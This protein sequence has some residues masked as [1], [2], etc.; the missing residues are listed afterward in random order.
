MKDIALPEYYGS[1]AGLLSLTPR[2]L[3]TWRAAE[4]LCSYLR[5]SE[6]EPTHELLHFPTDSKRTYMYDLYFFCRFNAQEMLFM[7]ESDS[8]L[9]VLRHFS[10]SRR[11]ALSLHNLGLPCHMSCKRKT[12]SC[13]F[14]NITR[15]PGS[16]ST[17]GWEWQACVWFQHSNP[18]SRQVESTANHAAR[19][20]VRS[21]KVQKRF[22]HGFVAKA[23][24]PEPNTLQQ[25]HVHNR[26]YSAHMSECILSLS[27]AC[28][29][30]AWCKTPLLTA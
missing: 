24:G 29:Y 26:G 23:K 16:E 7:Q 1:I 10:Y 21:S 2:S 9:R 17:A 11:I 12:L 20:I 15:E 27:F 19:A 8:F 3:F 18:P 13:T 30:D 5:V 4:E 22:D 6:F 25:P 14:V 28:V